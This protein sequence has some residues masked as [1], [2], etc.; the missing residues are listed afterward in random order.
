MTDTVGVIGLGAMGRIVAEHLLKSQFRVSGY[1]TDP[2]KMAVLEEL[3]L[4]RRD[5]AAAVALDADVLITS[6]PS[7]QAL[8]AV[9]EGPGGIL[10]T[11]RPGQI[12]IETCTLAVD[13]KQAAGETL[14]KS[15]RVMLDAPISGTPP[16][17]AGM[18]ASTF[19]GGDAAAYERCRPIFA[20]YTANHAHV[21]QVGDSSKM[22]FLANYLVYVHT[23]AAA[24]CMVLA[25][26]GGLDPELVHRVLSSS[27][28]AS[29]M[30]EVRGRMMADN[31][32]SYPDG[33]IFDVYRKDAAIITE[34]AAQVN[35]PVGLFAAARQTFNAAVAL[36]FG[37]KELAA[38]CKAVETAAG[39]E[40]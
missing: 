30:F 7:L 17:L 39:I 25:Q 26:K 21:G 24:E 35:A 31:D 32:Y 36:G 14:E 2:G 20:S 11:D 40:R 37:D 13:D 22:K 15:G 6:L 34:F 1:D 8:T 29:R 12:L 27:A 28:G 3:G 16:M 33:S 5:S 23:V 19:V 4:E 10:E 38:V 9:L 18:Q